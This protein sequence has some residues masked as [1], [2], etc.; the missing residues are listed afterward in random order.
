MR[1][2]YDTEF[3]EDGDTIE[4][5]SIGVVAED[6]R[7]F[8]RANYDCNFSRA[9]DWVK[10]NVLP[11]LPA[12]PIVLTPENRGIWRPHKEIGPELLAFL[13]YT[14]PEKKG[15]DVPKPV[16][17]TEKPEL[18]GY[19]SAYDHVALCQLFG[20]MIDLPKGMPMYTRDLKQWCDMLGNPQLPKQLKT[21]HDALADAHW[22]REVWHYLSALAGH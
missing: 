20:R 21:E 7:S 12:Q 5:I 17:P 1:Y 8:Y 22:N 3:I 6:G 19:Y 2:F 16:P 14:L 11:H 18:W 4:L 10:Q 9:N 15:W 13:G